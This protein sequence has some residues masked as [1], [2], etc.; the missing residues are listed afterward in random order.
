MNQEDPFLLVVPFLAIFS[1][2]NF[3]HHPLK[4]RFRP[5][6]DNVSERWPD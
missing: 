4:L 1:H 5:G 6:S 3:F 2:S